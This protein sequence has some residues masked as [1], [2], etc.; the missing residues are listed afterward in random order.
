MIQITEKAANEIKALM[1]K[2]GLEDQ[3]LRVAVAGGGCSGMSYKMNFEKEAV[4]GTF[5]KKPRVAV[6]EIRSSLVADNEVQI[7]S[8]Q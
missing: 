8:L 1:K 7:T 6:N 5:G 3:A 2:E 4:D